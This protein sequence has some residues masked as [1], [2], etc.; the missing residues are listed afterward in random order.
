MESE[1]AEVYERIPWETLETKQNDKRWLAYAVAGAIAVGALAYSFARSQPVEPSPADAAVASLSSTDTM[2]P[3]PG[4]A[5]TVANPMVVSEADLYAVEVEAFER[6]AMTHAE[7]AAMEYFSSDGTTGLLPSDL[8]RPVVPDGTS[9]FV[10]WAGAT[11]ISEIDHLNYTVDVVVRSLI[12]TEDGA[13]VRQP[14]QHASFEIGIDPEG[15]P[16]VKTA[17]LVGESASHPQQL[18]G[19]VE[20][21]SDL[22][23]AV[24]AEHG[25][26]VGGKQLADGSWELVVM[27]T[28]IDGIQRPTTVIP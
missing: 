24:E 1:R 14:T 28:G 23:S 3:A 18:A 5:P 6:V 11:A 4:P 16:F 25:P 17:P 2:A 19:L 26:V 12:A 9:V 20:P 22:I 21:P 13:F 15:R 7:W 8:P 27:Q 10:D